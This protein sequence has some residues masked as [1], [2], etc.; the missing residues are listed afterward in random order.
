CVV[1]SAHTARTASCSACSCKPCVQATLPMYCSDSH[2]PLL[3]ALEC[4]VRSL[5]RASQI[6]ATH[7]AA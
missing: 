7:D 6:L 3:C 2:D 1:P 4:K 5:Q